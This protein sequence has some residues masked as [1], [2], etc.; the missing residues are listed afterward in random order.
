MAPAGF[1]DESA[2]MTKHRER[3]LL[4]ALKFE[5]QL[6]AYFSHSTRSRTD[7]ED[8]LQELYAR[9][10]RQGDTD[11]LVIK[12]IRTF[13]FTI[14]QNLAIDFARTRRTREP[15]AISLAFMTD[16]EQVDDC[17]VA[18]EVERVVDAQQELQLLAAALADIPKRSREVFTLRKVYGHSQEEIAQALGIEIN[19]VQRHIGIAARKCAAYLCSQ[20]GAPQHYSLLEQFKRRRRRVGLK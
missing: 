15:P 20:P 10:L 16:T 11:T 2:H 19:T 12:S 5:P 6:R 13:A 9:L 8:L 18:T 3:F 17:Q 7:A 1:K 4:R 14:A